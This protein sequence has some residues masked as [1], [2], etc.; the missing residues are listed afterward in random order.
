[1]GNFRGTTY[2]KRHVSL[3]PEDS[4]FW[5]YSFDEMAKYDFADTVAN[6]LKKTSAKKL[7]A[8]GHSEGSTIIY[9][10]LAGNEQ[11]RD[12]IALYVALSPAVY[13]K[14]TESPLVAALRKIIPLLRVFGVKEFSPSGLWLAKYFP[15]ICVKFPGLCENTICFSA[16]CQN[17]DSLSK[18]RLPVLVSHYPDTTSVQNMN[19]WLQIY[20][21]D[22]FQKYDF[23][24]KKNKKKYGNATPPL[25]DLASSLEVPQ[26]IYYGSNDTF[27][28]TEDALRVINELEAAGNNIISVHEVPYGHGDFVWADSAIDLIYRPI[29]KVF[30]T[31]QRE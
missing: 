10:A 7:I 28:E 8:V 23:G 14:H 6:V 16:G 22:N 1:M 2:G 9:A 26:I 15:A 4:Q 21:S 24:K 13:V 17:T 18:D 12:S 27:I 19:H 30:S 11:L 20:K 5:D 25:Y 29:E 31:I 3:S